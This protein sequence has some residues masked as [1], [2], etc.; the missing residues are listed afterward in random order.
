MPKP[1]SSLSIKCVR[2]NSRVRCISCP[3]FFN[4]AALVLYKAYLSTS[5][6]IKMTPSVHKYEHYKC[7]I[8]RPYNHT[9]E[10]LSCP[11]LLLPLLW[12]RKN[13]IVSLVLLAK[14]LTLTINGIYSSV[15]VVAITCSL[16]TIHMCILAATTTFY[17][18]IVSYYDLQWCTTSY[19]QEQQHNN[20]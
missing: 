14:L 15:V 4:G 1:S 19:Q 10:F 8:R 5:L 18:F 3:P 9:R 20:K 17:L 6:V 7:S 12:P 16:H 11:A 13:V 2:N